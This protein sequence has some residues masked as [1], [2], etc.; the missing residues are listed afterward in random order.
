[1]VLFFRDPLTS[2][3]HEPDVSALI[4]LSDV[5]EI[6]L[7][8]NMGTAEVLVKGL[9]HGYMDW[10]KLRKN[11]VKS[12]ISKSNID[13]LAFGAHADDVEIGM[14]GTIAKYVQ[15]GKHIVICDLTKAEMSSNGSISLRQKEAKKAADILGVE[16][17]SWIY[18]TGGFI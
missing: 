16:R 11:K 13:I 3:P 12:M 5:Y 18:P 6:P 15:Q 2:Q 4:R 17:I 7:A 1:M 9:E 14:G 10:L 8:T